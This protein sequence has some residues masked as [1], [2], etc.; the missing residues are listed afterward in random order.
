MAPPPDFSRLPLKEYGAAENTSAMS[1]ECT[2]LMLAA[3]RDEPGAFERLVGLV[4]RR[5]FFVAR[6][7]VGSHEDAL[8][9]VQESLFK[10]YRARDTFRD[11]EPFLPWFHRILRNTCYSH[12]RGRGR[13]RTVSVSGRAP[14]ADGDEGDWELVDPDAPGP[15]ALAVAGEETARF[16]EALTRLS[17][18]DREILALRHA[19]GL[20]YREIA[21]S[22]GIPQGT[23]M[24]RLYHARRRLREALGDE[25]E[26]PPD[27]ALLRSL[28]DAP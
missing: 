27:G 13:L 10:V 22:L 5:A 23:V 1:A 4:R 28:E 14:G 3:R 16:R 17:A 11:G 25:P 7:L 8:D 12:L 6:G 15:D 26:A 2:E 9:L 24:S 21:D 19:Q 20:S 18:R